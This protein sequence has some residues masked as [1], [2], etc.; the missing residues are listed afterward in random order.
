[1]PYPAGYE[2]EAAKDLEK[3]AGQIAASLK[4]KGISDLK[5]DNGNVKVALKDA[6]IVAIIAYLQRMGKDVSPDAGQ[7]FQMS[8]E[9]QTSSK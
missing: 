6:E 9:K 2:N 5:D 4:Q 3:Q 8:Y 1:V 7:A